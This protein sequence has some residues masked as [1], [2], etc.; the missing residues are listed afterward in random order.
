MTHQAERVRAEPFY[1]TALVNP[2]AAISGDRGGTEGMSDTVKI[3]LP[4]PERSSARPPEIV[5]AEIADI[6]PLSLAGHVYT[7]AEYIGPCRPPKPQV[8]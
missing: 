8:K 3:Y 6:P 2:Y 4:R 1:P 7:E 5:P